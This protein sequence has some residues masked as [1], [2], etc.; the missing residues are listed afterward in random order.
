MR[1]DENLRFAKV[2][3]YTNP[4]PGT[5]LQTQTGVSWELGAEWSN[6]RHQVRAMVY[7]LDLDDEIVLAPGVG[8][9]G[10]PANT[11]LDSTRRDGAIVGVGFQ[12]ME[13]LHLSADWSWTDAR[14]RSGTLRGQRVPFVAKQSLRLG[15][16]YEATPGLTVLGEVVAVGDR[17]YSGDFNRQLPLFPGYGVVNLAVDYEIGDWTLGARVNNL[18]DK[19]Y[20][21]FGAN[22]GTP[23]A[24]SFYPAPERNLWLSARYRFGM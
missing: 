2:D 15:A 21:D 16:E 14:V 24:V 1:R 20:S 17:V 3:E 8:A 12:A 10:F 5:I 23:A 19:E 9:F 18:L 6:R 11:N 7:R 13:T 4:V 22:A